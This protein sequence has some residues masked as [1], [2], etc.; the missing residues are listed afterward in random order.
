MKSIIVHLYCIAACSRL[1]RAWIA[2]SGAKIPN[3]KA[4]TKLQSKSSAV[5]SSDF[6][7]VSGRRK[8]IGSIAS[9]VVGAGCIPLL[10]ANA[11]GLVST[12]STCDQSVS[13]WVSTFYVADC[14]H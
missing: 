13:A 14:W 11:V 1:S 9:A 5:D 7:D 12:A 3:R 8:W 10:P 6:E 2:G 4:P